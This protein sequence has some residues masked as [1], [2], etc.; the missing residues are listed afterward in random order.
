MPASAVRLL[1]G[2]MAHLLLTG[3][4]AIPKRTL[5][6]NCGQLSIRYSVDADRRICGVRCRKLS[7]LR[8]RSRCKTAAT[9]SVYERWV[10]CKSSSAHRGRSVLSSD[11]GLCRRRARAI[12]GAATNRDNTGRARDR[13]STAGGCRTAGDTVSAAGGCSTACDAC[14]SGGALRCRATRA[15]RDA[16]PT[17]AAARAGACADPRRAAARVT[18][19]TA[20]GR[21][22][23][24]RFGSPSRP[25]ETT[26][27]RADVVRTVSTGLE[28]G[29]RAGCLQAART[30]A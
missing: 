8:L 23:R 16:G 1:I 9:G 5:D 21:G 11:R 2:E 22:E 4:R 27:P 25:G 30:T 7:E 12:A 15:S 18:A 24:H 10:R 19:I 3:Q 14:A 13:A 26:D 28:S 29:R 20:R 6:S 17:A